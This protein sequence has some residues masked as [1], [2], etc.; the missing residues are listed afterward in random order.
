MLC[1]PLKSLKVI[2]VRLPEH[3]AHPTHST[4][5]GAEQSGETQS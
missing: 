2:I 4:G 5:G 3:T 1:K